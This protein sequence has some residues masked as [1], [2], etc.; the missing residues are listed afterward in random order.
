MTENIWR[1]LWEKQ[2]A[3]YCDFQKSLHDTGLSFQVILASGSSKQASHIPDAVCT[4]FELLMMGV[5][6][7]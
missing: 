5:E 3:Y 7:A 2:H 1:L 4:V 6:T